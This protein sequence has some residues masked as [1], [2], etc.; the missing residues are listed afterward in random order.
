MLVYR[1]SD[2]FQGVEVCQCFLEG[3]RRLGT[4]EQF[5]SKVRAQSKIY[6]FVA[7]MTFLTLLPSSSTLKGSVNTKGCVFVMREKETEP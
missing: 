7:L 3:P 6:E 5:I 1:H 4:A 2:H